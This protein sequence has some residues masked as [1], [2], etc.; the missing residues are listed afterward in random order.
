MVDTLKINLLIQ[1]LYRN[2]V[3]KDE[4]KSTAEGNLTEGGGGIAVQ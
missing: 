2:L 3:A 1:S 4:I